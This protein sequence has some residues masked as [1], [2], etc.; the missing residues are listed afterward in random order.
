MADRNRK[1][2]AGRDG[3]LGWI[4]L[5]EQPANSEDALVR[6][7][8]GTGVRVPADLL[9]KQID[10]SFYLPMSRTQFLSFDNPDAGQERE[11]IVVIPVIAEEMEIS[12][13]QVTSGRV[14]VTKHVHEREETVDIP[15]KTQEVQVERVPVDRPIEEPPQVR[16]EE[17]TMI[18]PVVEEVLVVKKQL[19]LKE[20]VRVTMIQNEVREPIQV[21]LREEEVEVNRAD[22]GEREKKE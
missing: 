18:I 14:Q 19:R 10:G 16:Y 15:T 13:R 5:D 22:P 8:N 11:T 2:L 3:L 12:K 9:V 21:T 7:E 4:D 6:L 1:T 20:E 17:D